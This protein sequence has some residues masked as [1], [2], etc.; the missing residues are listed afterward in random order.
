MINDGDR[1]DALVKIASSP[2]GYQAPEENWETRNR[3]R[4]QMDRVSNA[5][6]TV[7]RIDGV[8]K[9]RH[10]LLNKRLQN[11]TFLDYMDYLG[12]KVRRYNPFQ[13]IMMKM[14]PDEYEEK[15]MRDAMDVIGRHLDS[16]NATPGSSKDKARQ[17]NS[18]TP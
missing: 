5:F 12:E 16:S 6:D 8:R 3:A 11:P 13:R 18:R 2:P 1:V 9:R 7:N 17:V 15:A 4:L 14:S 10:A